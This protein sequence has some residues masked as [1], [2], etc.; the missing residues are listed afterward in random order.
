MPQAPCHTFCGATANIVLLG[1][2]ES[3]GNAGAMLDLQRC[4]G[5]VFCAVFCQKPGVPDEKISVIH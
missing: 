5:W 4:L 2:P 1:E 3:P